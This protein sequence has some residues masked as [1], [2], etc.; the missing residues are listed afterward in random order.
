MRDFIRFSNKLKIDFNL[1]ISRCEAE[2]HYCFGTS[3]SQK[4]SD[5]V[6]EFF[7]FSG[8]C[9]FPFWHVST[10]PSTIFGIRGVEEKRRRESSYSLL[11]QWWLNKPALRQKP[12]TTVST[13]KKDTLL[14]MSRLQ[15][16]RQSLWQAHIGRDDYSETEQGLTNM[17]FGSV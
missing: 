13:P 17:S 1:T 15:D 7:L 9:L 5:T 2:Q 10:F 14:K 8:M 6:V 11:C 12:T 16:N 4:S 3:F